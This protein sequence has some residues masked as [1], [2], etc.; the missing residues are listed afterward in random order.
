MELNTKLK[1][2]K[3][4]IYIFFIGILISC[5]YAIYNTYNFEKN[6]K[7]RHL[8]I[9]GD[10]ALVWREAHAFK[11]DLI[12]T[13]N[14]FGNGIAYTRTFL[15]SKTVALYSFLLNQDIYESIDNEKIK[16]GKKLVYLF[17][18]I[19]IYYLSLLYLYKKLLLFY[20][21]KNVSFFI[22]TYLALDP[23]I[24][25]WH[26]TFWTESI[27]ISMQVF[28]IG[29]IIDRNKTNLFCLLL[30][31]FLGL[32][33]L[34]KTVGVLFI[35]FIV[36]YVFFTE[37]RNKSI[38]ILNIFA[39]FFLVL[40]LLGFDNFKKTG[41]F[42]VMPTQT[43]NAHYSILVPQI[44]SEKKDY[45][46][47]FRVKESEKKWKIDNKFSEKNF[48]SIYNLRKFQQKKAL[49]IIS[50][51]KIITIKIYLKKIVNHLILN[52]FQTYYWHKY[53]QIEYAGKEFHLS[54]E[55]KKYFYF[56]V[57]YTLIFYTI[58]LIGFIR[59]KNDKKNFKFHLLLLFLVSYLA[60]MLGWVGN[61]RYFVP[62]LIFLSIF[63]GHGIDYLRKLRY[64]N[65]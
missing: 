29:M 32:I 8:M 56:K 20:D 60:F 25:Q 43:K 41:I 45:Q 28:L 6:E 12:E 18:Q 9:S 64:K 30:G 57:L 19:I 27:F 2:N 13:K 5:L 49:E 21:S 37:I 35:L 39:G 59:I 11:K 3:F 46:A 47:Y 26:G 55:A 51:N 61:S 52:P 42:Y 63:F 7:N 23:N 1:K 58:L 22:V 33:F 38:K 40:V 48:K 17:F 54:K 15:P 14:F 10:I 62:S 65:L 31:L 53:N 24:V 4:L 50:E 34:Q 44:F 16:E 36:F